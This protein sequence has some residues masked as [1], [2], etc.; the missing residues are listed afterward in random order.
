MHFSLIDTRRVYCKEAAFKRITWECSNCLFFTHRI[1]RKKTKTNIPTSKADKSHS[2]WDVNHS[3]M[4]PGSSNKK[5]DKETR[6]AHGEG[7]IM[8]KHADIVNYTC[9]IFNFTTSGVN[10]SQN[11]WAVFI[12]QCFSDKVYIYV[13]LAD[14]TTLTACKSNKCSNTRTHHQ[15]S[16]AFCHF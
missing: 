11:E 1:F 12:K 8:E 4:T 14:S 5:H 2:S 7:L 13:I 3:S 15:D 6:Y 10:K 9:I 16:Q